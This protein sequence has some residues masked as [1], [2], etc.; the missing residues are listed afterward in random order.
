MLKVQQATDKNYTR[1][2][3]LQ[4]A[5]EGDTHLGSNLYPQAQ[6]FTPHSQP[7]AVNPLEP[8]SSVNET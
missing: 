8:S 2:K 5:A 7:P 6:V 4:A 3:V 1:L